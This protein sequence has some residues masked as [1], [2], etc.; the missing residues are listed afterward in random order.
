MIRKAQTRFVS[1]I[2]AVLFVIMSAL[3][4]MFCNISYN[5]IEQLAGSY[6]DTIYD[7]HLKINITGGFVSDKD[8]AIA[9]KGKVYE[10]RFKSKFADYRGILP[11]RL[12]DDI[13]TDEIYSFQNVYYKM[14][15]LNGTLYLTSV[16]MSD[17][18]DDITGRIL[19]LLGLVVLS[20][21]LI[22]ALMVWISG[23]VFSPLK[24]AF[25]KQRQFISNASHEL[26]TP[27][28]IISAN[29]DVLKSDSSNQWIDNIKSQT[30]RM[31]KLVLDM[32]TLAKMDEHT[33]NIKVVKTNVSK[34]ILQSVLPFEAIAF[35][36]RK[37]LIIDVV[38]DVEFELNVDALKKIASILV[39]NAIKYTS[40][41][42]NI[43]VNLYIEGG[44]LYFIVKNDGSNVPD[45]KAKYLFERF[46]RGDESHSSVIKG[47]G[48]GLAIAKTIADNNKWKIY[49]E[50]KLGVSME[51]GVIIQ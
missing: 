3:F 47:S 40:Q 27:I 38:K 44:K 41:D 9:E 13:N 31:E 2:M 33:E 26:K 35:E 24:E 28:A 19:V 51:I 22:F 12:L 4:G 46:Y 17:D 8:Y 39:D 14:F 50:S 7:T 5:S 11:D 16:D 29:A 32:L 15:E 49:A 23:K 37:N 18:I 25:V 30:D 20:Y 48:L 10:D 43:Y 34:E 1:I 42:G 45:D 6:L 36:K 21:F